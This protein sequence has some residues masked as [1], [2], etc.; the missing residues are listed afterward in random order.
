MKNHLDK[1]FLGRGWS[2]PPQFIIREYYQG[3]AMTEEE[4]DIHQSLDILLSTMTGERIFRPE[5][6]CNTKAWVFSKM[7]ETQLTLIIDEIEQAILYGE[8]RITLEKIE[9]NERN[10]EEGRLVIELFY[11]VKQTNSRSN[12]VYPFYFEE[13]TDLRITHK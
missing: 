13:G 11:F 4:E 10:Y 7:S 3:I 8:P 5:Y 2:Y 9:I 12:I 6:G 1:P